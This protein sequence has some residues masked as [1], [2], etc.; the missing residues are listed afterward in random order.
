MTNDFF[1][2]IRTLSCYIMRLWIS[3]KPSVLAGFLWYHS[4]REKKGTASRLPA[5]AEVQ[6]ASDTDQWRWESQDSTWSLLTLLWW[7]PQDHRATVEVQTP[8]ENLLWQILTGTGEAPL[9]HWVRV[10]I[11][12]PL[13]RVSSN[14]TRGG[15]G[16]LTSQQ[17]WKSQ[18][19][20]WPSR[21]PPWWA[22]SGAALQPRGRGNPGGHWASAGG[23]WGREHGF[24]CAINFSV[25]LGR[26]FPRPKLGE[27]RLLL[28]LKTEKS[29]S[30]GISWLL[31]SSA[32]SLGD[33]RQKGNAGR[34]LLGHRSGPKV[35]SSL[36]SLHLSKILVCSTQN[37]QAFSCT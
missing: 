8:Y 16:V 1:T 33:R 37:G 2:V 18:L 17:G 29:V 19:P 3:F 11:Q 12:A 26:P 10:G 35:P 30:T 20:T 4:G 15:K 27:S 24:S 7:W 32:S 9:S 28:G 34:S 14:T 5:E 23:G 21:I 22:G 13:W 31:A 25:L 6:G 36:P